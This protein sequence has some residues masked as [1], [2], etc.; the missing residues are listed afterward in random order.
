MAPTF[1]SIF[2]EID[3]LYPYNGTAEKVGAIE[4]I[5]FIVLI[6]PFR[7]RGIKRDLSSIMFI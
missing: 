7:E 5:G 4:V 3:A 1:S 6:P 2:V